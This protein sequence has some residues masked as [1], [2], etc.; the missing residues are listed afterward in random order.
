[1]L[2]F[3]GL[4]R[5]RRWRRQGGRFCF[6]GIRSLTKLSPPPDSS[7]AWRCSRLGGA[8]SL[9]ITPFAV[10]WVKIFKGIAE[11]QAE[12]E[13]EAARVAA[14][15]KFAHWLQ[16]GAAKGLRRKHRFSRNADGWCE[17]ML[18]DQN[19]SS[20][21]ERDDLD[22]LSE[23]QLASVRG[24]GKDANLSPAEAQQEANQA[25]KDWGRQ[26]GCERDDIEDTK[27]PD[28]L[29]EAPPQLWVEAVLDAAMTFPVDTGLGWDGVHPRCLGRLSSELLD[30]L[31]LILR[32]AEK[33][34]EWQAAVE[35]IIIVLLP[36]SDGGFRPIGLLP[37]LPRL[38][39]RARRSVCI[40]WEKM[41]HKPYLY[42]GK[43]MGADVAAWQQ[44][45]RA[46]LAATMQ[47]EVGYAQ[48]LLDLVKAFYRIPH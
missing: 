35:L 7:R 29:G 18:V 36:K 3:I 21:C 42:G 47:H 8:A 41:Q 14:T 43:G 39:M 30:W 40:S 24:A 33:T 10:A 2:T 27:W 28:D 12:K 16:E 23:Q 34:G 46:E 1:M 26:W 13:E 32:H 5:H 38:W 17:S 31:V 15:I 6:I 45:A 48:V 37:L 22:G 11:K 9:K 44:A 19:G 25:A 20:T 4:R